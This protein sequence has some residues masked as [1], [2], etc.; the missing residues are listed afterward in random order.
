MAEQGGGGLG[1]ED[2]GALAG[3]CAACAK[4]PQRAARRLAADAGGR[5]ETGKLAVRREPRVPLHGAVACRDRHDGKT[6]VRAAIDSGESE[7]RRIGH[8]TNAAREL[9]A[10]GVRDLGRGVERRG[11]GLARPGE[12]LTG[13]EGLECGVVQVEVGP[14]AGEFGRIGQSGIRVG[15]RP[16]GERAGV[17]R[18]RAEALAGQVRR[19]GDRRR[20]AE[21]DSQPGPALSGA[22]HLLD[23]AEPHADPEAVALGDDGVHG[24]RARG[25]GLG[26]Q[27]AGHL[28]EVHHAPGGK[29]LR[30]ELPSG[31]TPAY[32]PP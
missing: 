28:L 22:L 15:G 30:G 9:R 16:A 21:E 8:L 1:V 6:R 18:Q 31:L 13:I 29:M 3:G 26:D 5:F 24:P 32:R 12:C 7:A 11:F 23:F 19:G 20:L 25:E 14:V 2:D 27:R 4:P 17:P 10:L